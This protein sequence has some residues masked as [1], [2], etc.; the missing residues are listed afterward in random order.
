[1]NRVL[2]AVERI[3]QTVGSCGRWLVVAL[4]LVTLYEITMRYL[5]RAPT[6]W[7]Y[8][9]SMMLGG[10]IYALGWS[11]ALLHRSHVRVDIFFSRLSKRGQ[12]I[13]DI[14]LSIVLFFPLVSMIAYRAIYWAHRA[15]IRGEVLMD[16]TWFPPAWPY[17]SMLAIGLCLLLIMGVVKFIRDIQIASGGAES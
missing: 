15:Y 12:A 11:Y 8:E 13:A 16:S 14:L 10:T 5:F 9:T 3:I 2:G 7:A 4:I 1:M 6:N 17:K